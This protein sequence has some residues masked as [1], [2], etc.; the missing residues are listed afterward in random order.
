MAAA[1]E[2]GG[3]EA[4]PDSLGITLAGR[5][6]AEQIRA[7][8]VAGLAEGAL[9]EITDEALEGLKF[10][11]ALP[12]DVAAAVLAERITDPIGAAQVTQAAIRVVMQG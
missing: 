9:P 2:D 11:A 10:S 7:L 5:V 3:V 6:D 12:R 1:L 4:T 8:A